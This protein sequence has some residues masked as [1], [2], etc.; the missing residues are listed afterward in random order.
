MKSQDHNTLGIIQ[1]EA[2]VSVGI[3]RARQWFMELETY[4]ERYVFETHEGFVF[5]EGGF[6][7]VGARFATRERFYGVRFSLGFE[8][9]GIDERRFEF[10]VVRPSLPIR[11][12]FSL[13]E[14]DVNNTKLCL[15]I[16][17]ANRA[18]RWIL[19]L[20]GIKGAIERQIRGEAAHIKASMEA[21]YGDGP[22]RLPG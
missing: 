4:P 6:G 12:A 17:A 14:V 7:Q 13:Q 22:S 3:A 1:A 15:E 20:P 8:L 21:I 2:V 18:G 5:S 10:R 16:E 19:G 11:G 9:T